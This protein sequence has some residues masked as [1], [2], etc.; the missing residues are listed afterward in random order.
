MTVFWM[1]F[2]RSWM[3]VN[4]TNQDLLL[5]LLGKKSQRQ[6]LMD[7]KKMHFFEETRNQKHQSFFEDSESTRRLIAKTLNLHISPDWTPHM[8]NFSEFRNKDVVSVRKKNDRPRHEGSQMGNIQFRHF[9]SC[10]SS[11]YRLY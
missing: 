9:P 6:V 5:N 10:N 2:F 7:D 8:E 1:S 11:M 4:L 3:K